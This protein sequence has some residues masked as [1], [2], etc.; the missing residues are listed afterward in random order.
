MTKI[1]RTSKGYS[2]ATGTTAAAK[3]SGGFLAR[4]T[5]AAWLGGSLGIRSLLFATALKLAAD[6]GD[7]VLTYGVVTFKVKTYL[8]NYYCDTVIATA[9][10][11]NC[12]GFTETATVTVIYDNNGGTTAA[13]KDGYIPAVKTENSYR[14]R[15]IDGVAI[16]FDG[17]AISIK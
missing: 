12:Y 9:T 7:N 10:A 14:I 6:D 16:D 2:L 17:V 4:T 13:K 5:L 3:M 1:N 11:R 8:H 15:K